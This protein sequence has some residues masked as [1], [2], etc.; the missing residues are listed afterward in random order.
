MTLSFAISLSKRELGITRTKK[1]PFIATHLK[2]SMFRGSA[3]P[4][5]ID[6]AAFSEAAIVHAYGIRLNKPLTLQCGYGPPK[7]VR[8]DFLSRVTFVMS[9]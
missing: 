5:W 7:R 6:V 2:P 3:F 8:Y 1:S 9:V 4:L